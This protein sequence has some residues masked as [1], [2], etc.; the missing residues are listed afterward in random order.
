MGTSESQA[1]IPMKTS[2]LFLFGVALSLTSSGL[3]AQSRIP[4]PGVTSQG[5]IHEDTAPL[6]RISPLGT[7]RL[8]LTPLEGDAHGLV[9]SMRI[10]SGEGPGRAIEGL[11]GN[12]FLATDVDRVVVIDAHESNRYPTSLRI[13]DGEGRVTHEREVLMLTDPRISPDGR[14]LAYR[15]SE[16]TTVL[17]LSTDVERDYPALDDF[18]LGMAGAIAGIQARQ[19]VE[20]HSWDA[21]GWRGSTTLAAWPVAIAF[22]PA[23]NRV[24][25]A[26]A[27]HLESHDPGAG[28]HRTLY[29]T[30]ALHELRDLR[31][32]GGRVYVG[33][34][35]VQGG[36]ALGS[37]LQVG[38]QGMTVSA[39]S[40][41][42][43]IPP[44]APATPGHIDTI[45]WPL[46]ASSVHP[47]GN[48]YGEYQYYGGS[49]YLHP[50]VDLLGADSE[51]LYSV[52]DGVVKAILTTSGTW[53]W[54]IAIANQLGS[55][56][57]EGYLYA[58]VD[59]PT[60]A[61]NI[62]DV[63][64]KGQYLGNLVPW[65]VAGFTHCHFARIED[66]GT[67]WNGAWFNPDN[68][69]IDFANHSD[70]SAP[71]FEPAIGNDLF[72]FC[73]NN[74]SSYKNPT[75]LTGVVDIIARIS[76]QASAPWR[77]AV[78]EI[79]YTIHP[80]ASPANPIVD[81]KLS[82]AFDMGLD[83]YS[84]GPIDS[85]LVGLFY[86]QDATCPTQGDYSFREFFHIITNSDGDTQ[87][88]AADVAEAWDTTTL[89]DGDYVITVT[90]KDAAGNQS[91]ASMTV[92]TN[93]GNP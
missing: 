68:P 59:A 43:S 20:L 17:D 58:H 88:D 69:H 82:V 29:R 51:P 28:A 70:S 81:D 46:H 7:Q 14:Y 27:N 49:P 52:A 10:D 67:T 22:A 62:G 2:S 3:S 19:G 8:I 77:C 41:W 16:R 79:R 61:V 66:S 84:G 12:G 31:Q 86:K 40:A 92:T 44:A 37:M 75:A 36:H 55:G 57:S 71:L 9:F 74:S 33:R 50:G 64:T 90:A 65:P 45:P 91:S 80:A 6:E 73:A 48:S 63:V 25:V 26:M 89:S 83:T 24:L 13:L 35:S 23:S 4:Q 56:T 72:A 32:V 54:R 15:T 78:Q 30:S 18:A 38:P 21:Q 34:R 11:R 85:F 5:R 93:N 53:H 87:Y 1:G 42:T 47:I 76:D 39:A 60:I